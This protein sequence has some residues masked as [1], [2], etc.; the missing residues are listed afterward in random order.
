MLRPTLVWCVLAACGG[1]DKA[2]GSGPATPANERCT[3]DADCVVAA[4]SPCNPCGHCPGE[5]EYATT[6]LALNAEQGQCSTKAMLN[7]S[8]PRPQC[9]PCVAA[10]AD[11][12]PHTAACK[13]NACVLVASP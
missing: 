10:P 5:A 1:A 9:S 13:A 4:G 7:G 3:T 12:V 8:G 6:P 11:Y 2:A